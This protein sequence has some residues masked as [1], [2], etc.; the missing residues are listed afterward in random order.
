MNKNTTRC[1]FT[2]LAFLSLSFLNSQPLSA[3]T[4]Y[5]QA[6]ANPSG[7]N[8]TQQNPYPSV[9]AAMRETKPGFHVII[10]AGTYREHVD[11][12]HGGNDLPDGGPITYEA[13]KDAQGNYVNVIMKGS[14]L[15]PAGTNAWTLDS[16]SIYKRTIPVRPQQVF[17]NFN[18]LNPSPSSA[19]RQIG[20]PNP[21]I[22]ASG[23]GPDSPV[24]RYPNPLGSWSGNKDS[25][26]A[27]TFYWD[28]GTLYVWLNGNAIPNLQNMEVS[29]RRRIFFCQSPYIQ[30]KGIK[31]RHSNQS[32]FAAQDQAVGLNANC[33]I[34]DC[35]VQWT[36]FTGIGMWNDSQVINCNVSYNG[37]LGIVNSGWTNALVRGCKL[38]FNNQRGFNP[39]W[40][41]GGFKGVSTY[42]AGTVEDC[43][44][45]G[46]L[47]SGIWF[48]S[49][50]SGA[51]RIIRN[52]YVHHNGPEEAGIFFESSKNGRIYNNVLVSNRRRGIFVA[53]SDTTQVYNNTVANQLGL[54][55]IELFIGSSG[56]VS[57]N[58]VYNNIIWNG[59][60]T[61]ADLYVQ[62]NGT[63]GASS[64]ICNYNLVWRSSGTITFKSNA[65]TWTSLSAWNT[66]TGYDANSRNQDPAFTTASGDLF[67]IATSSPAANAGTN[68]VSSILT[69]DYSGAA[70]NGTYDIGAYEAGAAP[71]LQTLYT[72]Q[73]PSGTSSLAA[74]VGTKFKSS[75]NGR[76]TGVR[77]Y[78]GAAEATGTHQVR[79]W[80]SSGTLLAGPYNWPITGGTAGWKTFTL[81][82][83]VNLTANVYYIA[84]VSASP[85]TSNR[86]ARTAAG[87]NAPITSGN[88]R[89]E[90]GAGLYSTTAGAMPNTVENNSSYFR[91][92]I[93]QP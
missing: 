59:S 13:A 54:T 23:G 60:T 68:L 50:T 65:G 41:A 45:N 58:T 22:F 90:I 81:P 70:R 87:F 69:T 5:V 89:A 30:L 37:A 6:G 56:S 78:T 31:F 40:H 17:V 3:G 4:L 51:L 14:D 25:M 55:S 1:Y 82:T 63:T 57:Y 9:N 35:D 43:E 33:S 24:V 77:I 48:D 15:F 83:A 71:A 39:Q 84:A 75:I 38:N 73:V 88:L 11:C 27:G 44:V 34:Q 29:Q 36:D 12:N 20:N 47:A 53:G 66:A 85:G 26:T 92:V 52:N 86:Y 2:V 18:D 76:I 74:E 61:N 16:G 21:A 42:T 64:N 8:G 49:A 46:N 10:G 28:Q 7:A 93:F 72:T 79:I 32:S 62:K 67:Q 80:N 91:D 19:L